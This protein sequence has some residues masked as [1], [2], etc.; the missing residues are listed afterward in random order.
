MPYVASPM[1]AFEIF[2]L[3]HHGPR[4]DDY[5]SAGA[6]DGLDALSQGLCWKENA[7]TISWGV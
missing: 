1:L 4:Q 7:D 5:V 2:L 3:L 6:R